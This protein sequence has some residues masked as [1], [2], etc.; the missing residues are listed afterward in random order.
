MNRNLLLAVLE[1]EAL[2]IKAPTDFVFV[3]TS[4]SYMALLSMCFH[5][6]EEPS[7]LTS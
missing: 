1:A 6:A 5:T 2:K 3:K 4:F 7:E